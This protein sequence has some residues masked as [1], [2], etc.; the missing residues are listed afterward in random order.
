MRP[1]FLKQMVVGGLEGSWGQHLEPI[2]PDRGLDLLRVQGQKNKGINNKH[3]PTLPAPV[4]AEPLMG[5]NGI[6]LPN[7]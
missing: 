3:E 4:S 1:D 5:M 2:K 6:K 7:H